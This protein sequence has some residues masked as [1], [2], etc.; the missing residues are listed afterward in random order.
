MR[1]GGVETTGGHSGDRTK[2]VR[3]WAPNSMKTVPRIGRVRGI[4]DP[5]S[6]DS[7]YETY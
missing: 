2:K 5:S 6:Y 7:K 3:Q 1:P 4:N